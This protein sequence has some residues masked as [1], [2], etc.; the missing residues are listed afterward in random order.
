MTSTISSTSSR[1]LPEDVPLTVVGCRLQPAGARRRHPG[2]RAA[3]F[4][5]GL[6]RCRA[7]RRQP[8]PAGAICPDKHIAAMALDNGIGGFAFLLRHSRHDRRRAAD[9]CRRQRRRDAR[10]AWSRCRRST[11]RA[12]A[13]RFRMP[14]WA[15]AT[16]I[17]RR[18]DDLI[19]THGVFEGYPDDRAKIRAEMDAV[20][21]HRE[22]VQ[23]IKEKTGGSTFKNPEGHSAWKLIDEAGC[24][25]LH[26]RRRAD[27]VAALQFHDQYRPCDR[28]R[29]R[30]SSARRSASGCSRIPASCSNGKSSG[31]ASS[32]R[33]TRSRS[34]WAAS[35]A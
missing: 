1:L 26:D 2:R 24:R 6:R 20:R 29:S 15:T 35:T 7:C 22:T 34:S 30:I 27:V 17:R 3:A 12:A 16:A 18:R 11:A 13:C 4:G 14:T 9:E 33:A 5:Q 19:F 31:S 21:H 32:C 8:H 25:G 10:T 28:L 23:P